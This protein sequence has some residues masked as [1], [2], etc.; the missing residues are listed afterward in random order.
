M[1]DICKLCKTKSSCSVRAGWWSQ[2]IYLLRIRWR[3][4]DS[5]IDSKVF[6]VLTSR[7]QTFNRKSFCGWKLGVKTPWYYSSPHTHTHTGKIDDPGRGP[8]HTFDMMYSV[9]LFKTLIFYYLDRFPALSSLILFPI[10]E[11]LSG[12]FPNRFIYSAFLAHLYGRV[13]IK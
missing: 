4:C 1:A 12:F 2:S 11:S 5:R 13:A 3:M 6:V 7:L 8:Q 9:Y 10:F